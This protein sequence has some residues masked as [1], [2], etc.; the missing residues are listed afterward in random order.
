[1]RAWRITGRRIG[2]V[3]QD[4][5]ARLATR[6]GERP[7]RVGAWVELALFGALECL[8]AAGESALDD[9]AL[10]SLST[11]HGPD[12]ALRKSL[13][14]A[15]EGPPLPIGF[16]NSQPGQVLPALARALRWHGDGRCL[17]A[18]APHTALWLAAL[19]AGPGG[20]LIGWVDEDAPG[21][22]DWLRLM[23]TELPGSL[24]PAPF[25]ALA[26]ASVS[27]VAADAH[28]LY[29]ASPENDPHE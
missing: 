2:P 13:D 18:R 8:D 14:E 19:R 23:P 20:L 9:T 24:T 1:M 21:R 11:L 10:L 15:R 6:L 29:I 25:E 3:P 17:T 7:R 26:S 28:T 4:W 16:L 22:S 5:R 27:I 12:V